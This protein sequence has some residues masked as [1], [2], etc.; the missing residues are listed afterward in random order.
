M[1]D[2]EYG[3]VNMKLT[4][5]EFKSIIS[6]AVRFEETEDGYIYPHQYTKEQVEYFKSA[7]TFWFDR[8]TA[9]NARTIEIATDATRISFDYKIIWS[10]SNDSV[11]LFVDGTVTEILYVKDMEEEGI[12][13]FGLPCGSKSVCIYLPADATLLVRDFELDGDWELVHKDVKILWIGDSITQGYGPL[14]SSCTYVSVANR[15]LNCEVI[16]QG[17]GSYVYDINSITPI[18]GFVPDI[19]IVAMGTNQHQID[20]QESVIREFYYELTSL[21]PDVPVLCITPIWRGDVPKTFNMLLE[22][23]DTIKSICNSYK[24]ISVVDGFSLVP[25]LEEYFL[26]KLHPNVLGSEL[27]GRNLA[28]YIMKIGFLD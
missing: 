25:H 14:R 2:V 21:Y 6:G 10:G 16:N 12:I 3:V 4:K 9:S 22:I 7:N 18:P 19:I 13:T 11:E 17:I 5:E 15:I 20:G 28:D 8:S 27:Y 23:R 26:D 1:D 24:H